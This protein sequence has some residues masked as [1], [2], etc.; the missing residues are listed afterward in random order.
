MS[1][2][3]KFGGHTVEELETKGILFVQGSEPHAVIK[4]PLI[5]LL[6]LVQGVQHA[7]MLLKHFDVML[8]PDENERVSVAIV[9]LKCAGLA[10]M[11]REITAKVLFGTREGLDEKIMTTAL[12]F[13]NFEVQV[14]GK[15]ITSGTWRKFLL[16]A[17]RDGAFVMNAPKAPFSD[18]VIVPEEGKLVIFLQEKQSEVAKLQNQKKRK[19]HEFFA[20]N[21]RKEHAKC[22]V[23]TEHLFVLI[24]D[25][26]FTD[27]NQLEKNE[28]VVSHRDHAS[29]I[30]PLLSL[31]R[32][33]NHSHV[34]K[35]D[36]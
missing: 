4:L 26:D 1:R 20:E 5:L 24:T 31:L 16:T 12:R 15:Q 13:K 28:I 14:A 17:K 29:V 35:L 7:P 36:F 25:E 34:H 22:D 3:D 19:V 11:G 18:G 33:F 6:S 10:E 27:N 30:G 21:V 2:D 9:A 8:S 32:L 23:K